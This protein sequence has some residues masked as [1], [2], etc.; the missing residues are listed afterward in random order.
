MANES[1]DVVIVGGGMG[2]LNLAAL[3]T[4]E[5]SKGV[6][7]NF[8]ESVLT[9]TSRAPEMGEAEIHVEIQQYEGEPVEIDR[10]HGRFIRTIHADVH[11]FGQRLIGKYI[12][13]RQRALRMAHKSC[14]HPA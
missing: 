7:L 9:L 14:N 3:L 12:H 10:R 5:E 4:N 8:A 2:G 6:R 13:P 11:S 1:F